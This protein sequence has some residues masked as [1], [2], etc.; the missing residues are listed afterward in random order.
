MGGCRP[1]IYFL[2]RDT[3][4]GAFAASIGATYARLRSVWVSEAS[5]AAISG[6]SSGKEL[7]PN[8]GP[9]IG[10]VVSLGLLREPTHRIRIWDEV[11]GGAT[12]LVPDQP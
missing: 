5:S 1:T 3:R 7:F 2:C 8:G 10:V 11:G 6:I 9:A 4:I 12:P